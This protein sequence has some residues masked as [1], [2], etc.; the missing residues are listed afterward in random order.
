MKITSFCFLISYQW[1]YWS[2]IAHILN[3]ALGLHIHTHT[4]VQW[5][6]C[7]SLL[8]LYSIS[9]ISNIHTYLQLT[10]NCAW[11]MLL[12]RTQ[13]H[14][15]TH[16]EKSKNWLWILLHFCINSIIIWMLCGMMHP[17]K[18]KCIRY[19]CVVQVIVKNDDDEMRQERMQRI[20][21]KLVTIHT[22]TNCVYL[23]MQK[24]TH[25]TSLFGLLPKFAFV[26]LLLD[27]CCKLSLYMWLWHIH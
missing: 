8:Q 11:L 25:P 5:T 3:I 21:S 9:C 17:L 20:H 6:N 4:T 27:F 23:Y 13:T 15:Y 24:H 16:R 14:T 10:N 18:Y 12:Q 1:W 26:L 7:H 2:K 22:H 19:V